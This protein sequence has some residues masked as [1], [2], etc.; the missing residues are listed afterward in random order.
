MPDGEFWGINNFLNEDGTR[1][2]QLMRQYGFDWHFYVGNETDYT[3]RTTPWEGGAL[4]FSWDN[5]ANPW[6]A[7]IDQTP[8]PARS[9]LS[10]WI[11]PYVLPDSAGFDGWLT[12]AKPIYNLTKDYIGIQGSD[13]SLSWFEG[14]LRRYAQYIPYRSAI[15]VFGLY[16]GKDEI[17]GASTIASRELIKSAAEGNPDPALNRLLTIPELAANSSVWEPVSA[18]YKYLLATSDGSLYKFVGDYPGTSIQLKL[19][20]G[21]YIVQVEQIQTY[22]LNWGIVHI[23]S[24]D[25]IL[26]EL[27]ASNT[28]TIGTVIGVVGAG[29]A[30]GILFTYFLSKA[31]Y[32]IT[33]DLV[34]LSDF[35]FKDVLQKD[36]DKETGMRRPQYSR[37]AE[38][39]QIQRAFHKMVVTFA[40]AVAQN[41]RFNAAEQRRT[42]S[43][44]SA[45]PASP[46]SEL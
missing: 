21:Q 40:D 3:N 7:P 26:E 34:L 5:R 24:Q 41:K 22:N 27:H 15:Y 16:P 6:V 36:L 38:L 18:L 30:V 4:D 17:V 14:P 1:T 9:Q 31:L 32:M 45:Q 20:D 23:V 11:P 33:R 46:R 39:W 28:K 29:C 12:F 8:E 43:M 25:D 13:M 35:K 19:S 2:F 42:M 44:S 10:L 37:I